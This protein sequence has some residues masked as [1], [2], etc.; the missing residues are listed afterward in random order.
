MKKALFMMCLPLTLGLFS[1]CSS[2]DEMN[3]NGDE[4]LILISDS[5][6]IP[7]D[8][9][10]LSPIDAYEVGNREDAA[11]LAGGLEG[12]MTKDFCFFNKELPLEKRSESF[13]VGSDKDECY[14]INSIEEL[15]S[16]YCGEKEIPYIDFDKYTLVIGQK[17]MPDFYHPEYKQ[18]LEFRNHRCDL[19]LYVPDYDP[20]FKAIQ[21]FYY[22]AF[23]PKFNTEGINNVCFIREKSVLK[24]VEDITGYVW[25]N[26]LYCDY[27][28]PNNNINK[29]NGVWEK[30]A[31]D[32][33]MIM[34]DAPEGTNPISY[35][36]INLPDDIV[37]DKVYGTHVR[38]SGDII[39]LNHASQER[40]SILEI[41]QNVYFIY[42][43]KIEVIN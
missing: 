35:Y 27:N 4:E 43:T 40:L 11:E 16:I 36:P 33:R 23:Y 34:G 37:V 42:L 13:F 7:D 20:G 10:V 30:N 2:D 19:N 26:Y 24:H 6:L 14:V 21:H 8:G 12:H 18:E 5:T 15:K 29:D 38:F 28:D 41:G 22:W 25:K 17:V 1:A 32:N 39:E 9:V 31:W 3:V